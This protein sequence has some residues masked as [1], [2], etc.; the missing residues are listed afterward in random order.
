MTNIHPLQHFLWGEFRK[1]TEV[2][3]I[4]KNNLQVT[5]HSIPH[6]N[7][8]IGYFP[9]GEDITQKM[10]DDLLEIGRQ[11]NCIFIQ[12]EPN[13][14]KK[15]NKKYNFKNLYPSAHPIFTKYNFILDLTK[16]EE[17]LL[18]NLS[19]KT[20][21]NIRLAQKKG[22]K[23]IEDN[24]DKAFKEY[25]K[26]TK[27]TTQRQKFFAHNERYHRL[28]WETLKRQNKTKEFSI[29]LFKAVYNNETLV[30]WVLFVLG[31]TL[32][33]PYG[34]SSEKYREVMASN[35]MMW[36]AIRFGKKLGLKKFDMWG[37]AN[38]PDPK[39]DNVYFGFHRFKQGYG[40]KLI[41]YVGSFDFVINKNLYFIYKILDKIRWF[42]LRIK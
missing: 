30:A 11:N 42:I 28:L 3:V 33:Y 20:R 22:V 5:I 21:Y 17:E 13:V 35:L 2:L 15:D 1:K 16:S 10:L 25:L 23:V 6:T 31:D 29:H 27:D 4:R 34:A 7:F 12:I 37:A 24:S 18:K 32:Y 38:Q 40:A 41:E 9:K 39:P 36:E 26:L 8:K 19:Q 14:E